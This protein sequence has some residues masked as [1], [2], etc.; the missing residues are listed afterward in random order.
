[1]LQR[2]SFLVL[3]V[4]ACGVGSVEGLGGTGGTDDSGELPP[5][6]DGDTGGQDGT[7]YHPVGF[8]SPDMHG[9]DFNLQEQDCRGCHGADLTGATNAPSCDSCHSA[10]AP[11]A[12]RSDCTF[13][14]GDSP[15]NL[16]GSITGGFAVPHLAHLGSDISGTINCSTCHTAPT[17]V[18]SEGHAFDSSPG[19]A[20]VAMGLSLNPQG[21]FAAGTCS[22]TY[23]HG[24]GRADNGTVAINAPAM[25]CDSCHAGPNAGSA[26][27]SAMS[28]DHRKHLNVNGI[29]CADCHVDVT[30]DGVTLSNPALHID[31]INQVASAEPGFTIAGQG[32]QVRCSGACH[33][34]NHNNEGW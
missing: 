17:D 6:S 20:E 15:K 33:G 4:A 29:T 13:C 28:G 12:W 7:A 24:N 31:G 5:G 2:F 21:S 22:N 14:H 30:T 27:W 18:M 19:A 32:A 9:L 3:F 1:M 10:Q 34:E 23:C 8:S 16:D 26:A 25:T 11:Q